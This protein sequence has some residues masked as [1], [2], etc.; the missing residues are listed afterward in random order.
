MLACGATRAAASG[1]L[2]LAPNELYFGSVW[3]GRTHT[4][5][6]TVRNSG[7]T[8]VKLSGHTLIGSGYSVSGITLPKILNA[9][10]AVTFSVHFAPART[11]TMPG[12]LELISNAENSTFVVPLFGAG[13]TSEELG[14]ASALP[15]SAHF[16]DVPVGTKNTQSVEI[17]NTGARSLAISSVTAKGSGFSVSG[18]KTP[19]SIPS[20]G[21][22]QITVAFL[23]EAAGTVNG[24]VGVKSS[25]SDSQLTIAVSGTGVGSSRDL[26]VSP[27]SVAFGKVNVSSSAVRE[28]TLKNA[29]NSNISISGDSV[30]GTGFSASGLGGSLTLSPGQTAVL[31]ADF[32]PKTAGNAAGAVTITSNATNGA[33]ITVPV[34][35]TGVVTS[36]SVG[37]N[38]QAS[39][40][41]GVVGYYVYRSTVSGGSYA[42]LDGSAIGGTSYTDAG[43]TAG[44]T[45]HYVVTALGSDGLESP[46]SNQVV[47]SVP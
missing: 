10:A 2:T 25:A 26:V 17:R 3:V 8:G 12:K 20:G 40:S 37:L 6:V 27:T 9:G 47:V 33:S 34:T 44:T 45:Y 46:H 39:G 14:Y 32:A 22:A 11:G 43:V 21:S 16:G 29:G 5:S 18:I 4:I 13:V 23:P 24:S 1:K 30:R 38:W 35:A 19:L 15:M 41:S 42:K 31:K 7:T 36:H 28:I